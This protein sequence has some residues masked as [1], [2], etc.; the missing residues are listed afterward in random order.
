MTAA[1]T[2]PLL[3]CPFC[4]GKAFLR[5]DTVMYGNASVECDEC[6]AETA[7]FI[8]KDAAIA[9]WNRRT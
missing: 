8:E 9:A 3:P 1:A 7:I 6:D 5:D 2:S 4:G